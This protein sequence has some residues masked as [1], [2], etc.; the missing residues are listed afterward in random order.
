MPPSSVGIG[1][2]MANSLS[3]SNPIAAGG[4]GLMTAPTAPSMEG[5]AAGTPSDGTVAG[6]KQQKSEGQTLVDALIWR[7]KRITPTQSA[8]AV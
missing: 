5:G 6:L 8:A 2:D 4:A 3:P 7:L 1:A